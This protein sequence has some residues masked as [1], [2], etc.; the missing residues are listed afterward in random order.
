MS[1]SM[2]L[3]KCE[4]FAVQSKK[5]YKKNLGKKDVNTER[6]YKKLYRSYKMY[7]NFYFWYAYDISTNLQEQRKQKIENKSNKEWFSKKFVWNGDLMM[8]TEAFKAKEW[9]VPIIHGFIEGF[10]IDSKT[11]NLPFVISHYIFIPYFLVSISSFLYRHQKPWLRVY[12]SKPS[13]KIQY[14]RQIP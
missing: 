2:K 14:R 12:I 6:Q 11:G 13:F 8:F 7:K 5:F 9:L 3:N 1:L 10:K 4:L